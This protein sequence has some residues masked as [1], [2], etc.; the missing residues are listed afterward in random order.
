MK[1]IRTKQIIIRLHQDE[2]QQLQSASQKLRLSQSDYVRK[3]LFEETNRYLIDVKLVHDIRIMGIEL[4]AISRNL[5]DRQLI[6]PKLLELNQ[7]ISDIKIL[8]R[9]LSK[10]ALEK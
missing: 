5:K 2:H 4:T 7:L 8:I 6:D 10:E 3:K 1:S 9:R